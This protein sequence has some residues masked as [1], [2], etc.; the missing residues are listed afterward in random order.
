VEES[1]P[2]EMEVITD[3]VEEMHHIIKETAAE[4]KEVKTKFD[5]K[6]NEK[7]VSYNNS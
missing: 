5:K 2:D 7:N 1:E 3:K 4:M 6:A